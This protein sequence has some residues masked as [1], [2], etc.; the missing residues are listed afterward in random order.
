MNDSDY[1]KKIG[2]KLKILRSLKGYS[3]D[4]IVSK[5]DVDKSY[6]S[7]IERGLSNPTLLYIKHISEILDV[8]LNELI[9]PKISF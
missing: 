2:L 8:D 6:Y 7:K 4:D 3:Q 9:D 5:L 1:L